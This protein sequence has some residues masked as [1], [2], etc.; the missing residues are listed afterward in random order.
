MSCVIDWV[1]K[2]PIVSAAIVV[3]GVVGV[4]LAY[5][6]EEGTTLASSS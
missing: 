3:T 6:Q 2:H 4:V 5:Q 1:K